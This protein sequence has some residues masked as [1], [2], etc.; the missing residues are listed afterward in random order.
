ML[1][2]Y[3]SFTIDATPDFSVGRF[4]ARARI[5]QNAFGN[6]SELCDARDLGQFDCETDAADFAQLWAIAWIDECYDQEDT[7]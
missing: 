6:D 5:I 3:R 7:A 2:V 1:Y 4:F